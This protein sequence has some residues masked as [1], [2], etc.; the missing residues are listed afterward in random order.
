MPTNIRH[1]MNSF[2]CLLALSIITFLAQPHLALG[3]A[4]AGGVRASRPH[5]QRSFSHRFR[6]SRFFDGDEFDGGDIIIQQSQ[7]A[8][9]TTPEKPAKKG[10]YVQPHWVDGG[11]GVQVLEPGHWTEK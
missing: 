1:K 7:S 8:P 2:G 4:S 6:D 10:I 3:A 5:G 11:Y 9:T